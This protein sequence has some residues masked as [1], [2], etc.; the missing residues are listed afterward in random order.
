MEY[1][2]KFESQEEYE[3][4]RRR[5]ISLLDN[6]VS[7]AGSTLKYYNTK[8]L[9]YVEAIDDIVLNLTDLWYSFDGATWTKM[10]TNISVPAGT[11][12]YLKPQNYISSA[13]GTYIKVTEGTYNIGGS[14]LNGSGDG[15][16]WSGDCFAGETG[17]ISAENLILSGT[18]YYEANKKSTNQGLFE[19]CT[20]LIKAPKVIFNA[21]YYYG[22]VRLNLSQMFK[23]CTSLE[24]APTILVER[25]YSSQIGTSTE[26]TLTSAFNGC[27][28]LNKVELL[29]KTMPTTFDATDWLIEVAETGL[30]TLNYHA[31]STLLESLLPTI[32]NTWSI[33][34]YD[35]ETDKYFIKFTIDEVEYIAEYGMTW[36]SW[37]DSEYNTLDLNHYYPYDSR[38]CPIYNNEGY[39]VMNG[40]KVTHE[41]TILSSRAN[42]TIESNVYVQHID[43]TLYTIDEWTS[44]EFSNDLANG[45]AITDETNGGIVVAKTN[46]T[47]VIWGPTD[48]SVEGTSRTFGTGEAN[49]DLIINTLGDSITIES[50]TYTT[51]AAKAAKAYEFPNGKNGFLPSSEELYLLALNYEQ[52]N[53]IRYKIGGD[54]LRGDLWSSSQFSDTQAYL[55]YA[56]T[57]SVISGF[58]HIKSWDENVVPI[59]LLETSTEET[60]T[61]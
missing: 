25:L 7:L 30:I 6:S 34:Y 38:K 43:G 36:E 14:F 35:S 50:N 18:K 22:P 31:S 52:V 12:I 45:V 21:E 8:A 55:L 47:E 53:A 42:Y 39:L 51:Y 27:S 23:G 54:Q 16:T 46:I 1:I 57:I 2:R 13:P 32:P 49:T 9:F 37:V 40:V 41:D 61:E 10:T 29:C 44:E 28:N 58:N 5:L 3:I 11:R 24:E 4:Y 17:L 59:I 19:G 48:V 33:R 20:N 60:T 56:R 26:L 15:G